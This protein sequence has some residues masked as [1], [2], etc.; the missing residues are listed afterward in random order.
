MVRVR[1]IATGNYNKAS[2]FLNDL[3]KL[4][5]YSFFNSVSFV[6][7]SEQSQSEDQG[8]NGSAKLT[9]LMTIPLLEQ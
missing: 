3:T 7:I 8:T 1:L 6:S 9:L 2:L 5:F 4:E